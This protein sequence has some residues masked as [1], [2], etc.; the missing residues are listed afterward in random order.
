MLPSRYV[1]LNIDKLRTNTVGV[2]IAMRTKPTDQMCNCESKTWSA[3]LYQAYVM[4]L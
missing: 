3:R 2:S 4:K 1:K